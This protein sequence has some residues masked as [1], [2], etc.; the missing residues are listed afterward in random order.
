L[1]IVKRTLVKQPLLRQIRLLAAR[2]EA[3][4]A[5]RIVLLDQV[6]DDGA[7]FPEREIGVG[8]VDCGHAAVGI[9]GEELGLLDVGELDVLRSYARPSSSASMRTLGGLGPCLP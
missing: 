2:L 1:R 3:D 9:Y 8:V 5:L 4:F 6:L 7:G